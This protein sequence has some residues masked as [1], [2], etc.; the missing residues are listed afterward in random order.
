MPSADVTPAMRDRMRGALVGLAVGDAVG[1]TVE[2]CP[3]GSFPPVTDM[4]GGGPFHLKAGEWTDDTSMALCLAESL[5][6]CRGFDATDQMHRYVRWRDEGH[7][8]STGTCFDIGNTV[9][10]ALR[11]FEA[12]GEPFSGP[13]GEMT[14]GN[15]SLM[16]LAPIPMFFFGRDA[17]LIALAGDSSRTTH[18]AAVAVD[19]CRYFAA[20]IAGA[21][22]GAT[23]D[24]LLSA[25]YAPQPGYW[26]EHPLH[27]VIATIADGS[28]KSK[29]PPAIR[30]SGYAADA[31]E[32]ALWAFHRGEDFREGCLLAVNLGDDA[33]TTAA[34]YG[35]L[36]GAFHG[37]S[38]IPMAWR[39]RLAKKPLLDR[40]AELLIQRA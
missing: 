25:R 27:P 17:D 15:G 36:A 29:E 18:G 23:K 12:S 6:A 26:D 40:Y 21:I 37:E 33:D 19:A 20:L 4:T 28:F 10:A 22:A 7:L 9:G 32:A 8:S 24:E 1:T 5:I 2:F 39:D 16:R 38:G 35:Q 3:P 30:G 14:A 11:A 34:I 31:L 13:T